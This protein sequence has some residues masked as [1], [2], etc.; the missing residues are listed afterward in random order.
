MLNKVIVVYITHGMFLT[1]A[2]SV[3]GS[4]GYYY[5]AVLTLFFD[6]TPKTIMFNISCVSAIQPTATTIVHVHG[7]ESGRIFGKDIANGTRT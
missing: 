1:K 4:T 3:L 5:I 7:D 6:V 2:I